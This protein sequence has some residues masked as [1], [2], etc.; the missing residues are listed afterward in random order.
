MDAVRASQ[1][2]DGYPRPQLRRSTWTPLDGEWDFAFDDAD[3]GRAARWFAAVDAPFDRRITVP[4]PPESPMSGIGDTG[5]HPVV[6]YRR[7]LNEDVARG[8]A[9]TRTVVH[10]Q[11]VD[12][13][14]EVWC[15]GS[16]VATHVGGQAP[17]EAD[18]TDALAPGVEHVL[19][20]R[21]E[22]DPADVEQ[23]R[24]KQDWHAR[25]HDIWY[26]RTTGI[27]QPVWLEFVPAT[28]VADLAWSVD[29]ARAS[30]RLEIELTRSPAAPLLVDVELRQGDELLA[31]QSTAMWTRTCAIDI[32]VDALRNAQ[33][34]AR[35]EWTPEQPVLVD[36]QL[37]LRD[38]SGTSSAVVDEVASYLGVRSV[39]A[40][41][42]AFLL[43]GRPTYLRAVLNQ[44]Y[45]RASHLAAAE[46]D[47]LRDEVE[48]IVQ[49]GFNAV[50][51]HQ[52]AADP[53]FLYWADR[54]GLLVWGEAA[55]AYAWSPRAAALLTAEWLELI[56]RDRS[57]PSIVAWVP[58]NESW[59][60]PEIAHSAEQQHFSRAIA[61]LTR[62]LDPSR[63]VM[64]NEGWEH[65]DSDIIG[66]HDY[67]TDPQTLLARYGRSG[68]ARDVATSAFGSAGRPIVLGD[69]QRRAVLEG[70]VPLLLTEFGGVSV[71]GRPNDG[72]GGSWGYATVES[73]EY[74]R[75]LRQLFDAV[76]SSPD[77]AGFCYTQLVDT[78]QETNGLVDVGGEPKLP[79]HLIREIVTGH[80]A[81]PA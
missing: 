35:L 52:R 79:V 48:L 51:V 29:V 75:L 67:S 63:P 44:G 71:S 46:N 19:V 6:W 78:A 32:A 26:E 18:L 38:R 55:A 72:G 43:N 27:W 23:P 40:S 73:D 2:D 22:D 77:L 36:A 80:P 81:R 70:E 9:G 14:A 66:I 76:R 68:G 13:R 25:P 56:R 54:L 37:R 42:G 1:Q 65:V 31:A 49:L 58:I 12:H 59:G 41:G 28:A 53:R 74:A 47:L 16:L 3:T 33:D 30:V 21:A 39:A 64:S 61:G 7:R 10:F 50:R 60:V 5:F 15:D 69:A 4:F 57:H 62:A 8:P 34:R 17:F 24:G 20:V 45:R 11:A